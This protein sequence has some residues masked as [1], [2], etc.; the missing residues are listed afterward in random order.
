ML[1]SNPRRTKSTRNWALGVCL[2]LT[3]CCSALPAEAAVALQNGAIFFEQ[4][5][6]LRAENGI[7]T[8][9]SESRY[10]CGVVGVAALD[11]DINEDDAGDIIYAY[12]Y[13]MA[14]SWWIK[15]DFRSHRGDNET[16]NITV[17]CADNSQIQLGGPASKPL[18]LKTF[19]NLGDNID[20]DTGFS[21][22]SWVCGIVGFQAL[23]GD[24]NENGAGTILRM[25]M[26]QQ[27]GRWRIRGDFRSHHDHEN[28]GRIDVLCASTSVAT[29]GSP[30][31]S[32]AKQ[33]FLKEYNG[34]ASN[35]FFNTGISEANFVCGV[36][37]MEAYDGD[38]EEHGSGDII[39]AYAYRQSGTWRIRTDFRTHKN[40]ENWN[41]KL[42]CIDRPVASFAVSAAPPDHCVTDAAASFATI[43]TN[44]STAQY[45]GANTEDVI[46]FPRYTSNIRNFGGAGEHFQGIARLQGRRYLVVSGG[47]KNGS[48]RRSELIV[49]E[50][51]SQSATG[52]WALPSYG[53]DYR[54]P[55]AADR[56]ITVERIDETLWHAGGIQAHGNVVAVPIFGDNPGSQGSE[57][58]F[59][60]L[61]VPTAPFELTAARIDRAAG[62]K[63][64]AAG[65]ARLSD[66]HYMTLVWDDTHLDFY[67]SVSTSLGGGFPTTFARVHKDNVVGGF[68][69][70]GGGFSGFGTYQNVNLVMQ[71]DGSM[72]LVGARNKEKGS[73]TFSTPGDDLATLYRVSWPMGSSG[74][75]DYTVE[76]TIYKVD[77]QT[78][79]CRNQQCNF[80]AGAG[81]YTPNS[82]KLWLY[83]ASHWFH[84]G[85]DRYNFNEYS[86]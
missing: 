19:T 83:G 12:M 51:G 27:Y 54:S 86:Y 77:Q 14:G 7:N 62:L 35:G 71:C 65:L 39:Q 69:S 36:V 40:H 59:Y 6:G 38:I 13:P 16:W 74:L 37:G 72:Y 11:G 1:H 28:W 76:P 67:R 8:Y 43:P 50:M 80:G 85:N 56:L 60:D 18:F 34:L 61:S 29:I 41:I 2:I 48:P 79:Y 42:L 44:V 17:L 47:V 57:I 70:G 81:V 68:Q 5:N 55:A 31:T 53:Y 10:T 22:S 82:G 52:A 25:Y 21:T 66:D 30:T 45:L 4:F 3:V 58:R 78:F 64:N 73:P 63:S 26:R 75:P 15:A 24:I 46:P 23:D 32:S 9:I 33:I 49:Y 20:H 84:D